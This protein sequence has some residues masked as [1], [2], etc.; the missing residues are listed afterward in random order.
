M[1]VTVC[2]VIEREFQQEPALAKIMNSRLQRAAT[3]LQNIHLLALREIRS[4]NSEL[5]IQLS[6]NAKYKIR[7]RILQAVSP[8]IEYYIS[9][10]CSRLGYIIWKSKV[11]DLYNV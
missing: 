5:D 2:A 11:A 10:R 9:D 1:R 7:Y 3:E 8:R 6:Y 4:Q